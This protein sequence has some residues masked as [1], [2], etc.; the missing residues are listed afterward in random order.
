MLSDIAGGQWCFT[1]EGSQ[2]RT[3]GVV[4][5]ARMIIMFKRACIQFRH[6]DSGVGGGCLPIT[7][8]A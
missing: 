3:V 6:A 5:S 4:S 8:I 2:Q 7:V 1:A